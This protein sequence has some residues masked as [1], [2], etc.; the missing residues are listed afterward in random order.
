MLNSLGYLRSFRCLLIV[1]GL[2]TLLGV[3]HLAGFYREKYKN[4]HQLIERI[5]EESHQSCLLLTSQDEPMDMLFVRGNKVDSIQLGSLGDAAKE[6]FQENGLFNSNCW[7]ILIQRYGGNPLA[8]K[9]VSKMIKELFGGSV[10]KFIGVN[11]ELNVVVPTLF[12]KIFKA[13]FERLSNL[14][15]QL[16]YA[17]AKNRQPADL[18]H[19]KEHFKNKVSMSKLL[20]SLTSLKKRSLIEVISEANQI[21]FTLQPMIMKYLILEQKEKTTDA[22]NVNS[23]SAENTIPS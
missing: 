1:D 6:I 4:Y 10:V 3:E 18:T 2:E 23:D 21:S 16:M 22:T 17:L 9:L 11:T 15:K 5:G 19:L 8:L 7:Q 20:P 13:Q 14:E 12:Q